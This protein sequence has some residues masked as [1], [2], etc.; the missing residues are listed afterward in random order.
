VEG[1]ELAAGL[2]ADTHEHVV[3]TRPRPVVGHLYMALVNPSTRPALRG[4][5]M[6]RVHAASGDVLDPVELHA[7]ACWLLLL[8]RRAAVP[9]NLC[10]TRSS[11]LVGLAHY[12]AG[13]IDVR[14][15]VELLETCPLCGDAGDGPVRR[16]V[17][18]SV[19]VSAP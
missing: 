18:A 5:I 3:G 6:R 11:R 15:A 10:H 14:R 16:R 7:V 19:E 17:N 8:R 1:L 12:R 9:T 13:G 4:I 2:A